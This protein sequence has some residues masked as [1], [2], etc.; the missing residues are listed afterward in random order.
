MLELFAPC[1]MGESDGVAPPERCFF[2]C[3]LQWLL[4]SQGSR[5]QQSFLHMARAGVLSPP[6]RL[7][8]DFWGPPPPCVLAER[9]VSHAA[10]GQ[11]SGVGMKGWVDGL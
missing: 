9:E 5:E 11:A 8:V 10:G 2:F 7:Y 3:I 6:P 1:P 4:D